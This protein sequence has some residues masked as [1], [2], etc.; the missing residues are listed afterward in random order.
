MRQIA[1]DTETTGLEAEK[2]HRIIEIGC[3][4][5]LDRKLTGNNFHRYLNPEREVEAGALTI[6]GITND[7]LCDKPIFADIVKEFIDYI[8]GAELIAHNASFDVGFI[9]HELRLTDKYHKQLDAYVTIFDTLT[10]ARQK[11]PGQRN[12][13]DAIC[14]RY[15]I[16]LSERKL[17]SAL[18]DA[19][20][21]AEAYLLMTG[22]QGNLFADQDFIAID[23]SSKDMPTAVKVRKKPATVV[24]YAND[25]ELTAHTNF[26]NTI[27]KISGRPQWKNE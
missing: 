7:F 24:A 15:K 19:E 20:L 23:V 8:N 4:E 27:K 13:L 14:K 25:I 2:G 10:L 22:G 5:L 18:L 3:V 1:I 12:T 26:L 21:L 6:H 16:D 9:N 17:H 11:F